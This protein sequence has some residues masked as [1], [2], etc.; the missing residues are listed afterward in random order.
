MSPRTRFL[1]N[2]KLS[3]VCLDTS[4]DPGRRRAALVAAASRVSRVSNL[5]LK[6]LLIQYRRSA[7]ATAGPGKTFRKDPGQPGHPGHEKSFASDFSYLENTHEIHGPWTDPGHA[8][9]P[10]RK[11]S[12]AEYTDSLARARKCISWG[13]RSGMALVRARELRKAV[14]CATRA[15]SQA[16]SERVG[17]A[18]LLSL[19]DFSHFGKLSSGYRNRCRAFLLNSR[20][21]FP[22]SSFHRGGPAKGDPHVRKDG[23]QRPGVRGA[24]GQSF[25]TCMRFCGSHTHAPAESR[26]FLKNISHVRIFENGRNLKKFT[27]TI[28]KVETRFH[29]RAGRPF[30]ARVS[31]CYA[32]A[33]ERK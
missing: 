4:L 14:F 27:K 3:R 26:E 5:F 31:G 19:N 21:A 24:G 11:T 29:S 30:D 1:I 33:L 15:H 12:G 22:R 6:K 9:H 7:V 10:G 18:R 25:E 16:Q 17:A 8:G 2:S 32:C 28:S 23:T 20:R 13:A